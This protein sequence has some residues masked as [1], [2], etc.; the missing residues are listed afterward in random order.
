MDELNIH[1]LWKVSVMFNEWA[2]KREREG[3]KREMRGRGRE[4][5]VRV[6]H[7]H[8]RDVD[9]LKMERGECV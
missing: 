3:V 1:L 9:T 5:T 4:D 6:P 2:D 7:I 8:T